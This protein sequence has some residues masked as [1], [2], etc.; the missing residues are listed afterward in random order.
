MKWKNLLEN[1]CPKC[2]SLLEEDKKTSF[3][4]CS[5][6]CGFSINDKKFAGLVNEM[7]KKQAEPEEVDRSG[8]E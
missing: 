7:Y 2:S 5:N 4:V 8:W 3:H 1:K 6:E